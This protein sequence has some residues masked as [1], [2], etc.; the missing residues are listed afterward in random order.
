MTY[1]TDSQEHRVNIGVEADPDLEESLEDL[2]DMDYE[3]DQ[4]NKWQDEEQYD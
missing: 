1:S 3:L 2:F 4:F